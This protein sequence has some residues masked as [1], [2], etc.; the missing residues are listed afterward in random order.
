MRERRGPV[1]QSAPHFAEA[2][3]LLDAAGYPFEV[4]EGL[5]GQVRV[6]SQD[7]AATTGELIAARAEVPEAR[8]LLEPLADIDSRQLSEQGNALAWLIT[9]RLAREEKDLVRREAALTE[10]LDNLWESYERRRRILRPDHHPAERTAPEPADGLGSERA[11]FNLAGVYIQLAKVHADL[12]GSDQIAGDLERAEQVYEAVRALRE[13]RY[14]GRP[15][16][17][18]AACVQGQALVAYYRAVLLDQVGQVAE[19]LRF[20]AEAMEQRRKVAAGL[21]GP[22]SEAILGDSD[23]RKSAS[24]IVKASMASMLGGEIKPGQGL[25]EVQGAFDEALAEWARR[26]ARSGTGED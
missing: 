3:R 2:N 25:K 17:H 16:P 7:N 1:R 14:G 24:F 10:V 12:A 5:I 9:R 11:Y 6:V 21:A 4:A 15:H 23:M 18:V 13:L 8:R 26:P 19:A 20:A 22:G